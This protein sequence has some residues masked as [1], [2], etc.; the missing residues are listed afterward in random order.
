[1]IEIVIR[2]GPSDAIF[3]KQVLSCVFI[4]F[5]ALIVLRGLLVGAS[6]HGL[7]LIL[8]ARPGCYLINGLGLDRPQGEESNFSRHRVTMRLNRVNG[9]IFG[10]ALRGTD[11]RRCII[12]AIG[13]DIIDRGRP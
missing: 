1:M 2:K 10:M 8:G 7:L 12:A 3:L 6:A 5:C 4:D 11:C 9:L 13:T